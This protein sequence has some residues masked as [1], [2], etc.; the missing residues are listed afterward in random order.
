MK[1]GDDG[2]SPTWWMIWV[3]AEGEWGILEV[4]L[5]VEGLGATTYGYGYGYEWS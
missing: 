1:Q 4:G 3:S 2:L 5:P